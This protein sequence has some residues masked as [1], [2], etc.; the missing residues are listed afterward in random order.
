MMHDLLGRDL[1]GWHPRRG[2]P[3]TEA[4][5]QQKLRSLSPEDEWWLSILDQG[6]LPGTMAENPTHA[7]A[8]S[9][10]N[11]ARKTAPRLR[12]HSDKRLSAILRD[13]RRGGA[14]P[15][16][17]GKERLR[18]WLF[19][20]L[21][22]RRALWAELLADDLGDAEWQADPDPARWDSDTFM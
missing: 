11:H 6:W 2:V 16:Q 4:L 15:T 17:Y 21:K 19:P 13:E 1:E 7:N 18:G 8:R 12:F 3:Q 5:R 20:D 22:S 9:L 10:Y 14:K